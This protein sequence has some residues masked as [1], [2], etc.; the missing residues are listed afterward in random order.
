MEDGKFGEEFT[1]TKR[2]Q[3]L[4]MKNKF[5]GMAYNKRSNYKKEGPLKDE[6]EKM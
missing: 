5:S 3:N 4:M 6:K 2:V 1:I